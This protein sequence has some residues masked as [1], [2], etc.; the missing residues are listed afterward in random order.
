MS[1]P[2]YLPDCPE[3]RK[4]AEAITRQRLGYISVPFGFGMR[5]RVL[6]AILAELRDLS[7]P[8]GRDQGC[9]LLWALL[10]GVEPEWCP[11]WRPLGSQ[12]FVLEVH[13]VGSIN[14]VN[15]CEGFVSGDVHEWFHGERWVYIAGISSLSP[16]EAL[17]AAIVAALEWRRG[18][19]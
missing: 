18:Q 2:V 19:P 9:R 1:D 8:F 12:G 16:T 5:G 14:I 6:T 15:V 10:T 3:L 11:V 7:T 17:A 4:R 13:R